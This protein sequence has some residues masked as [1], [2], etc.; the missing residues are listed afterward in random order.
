MIKGFLDG[1][2]FCADLQKLIGAHLATCEHCK[3]TVRSLLL[4]PAVKMM[5]PANL[6]D[7]LEG[8]VDGKGEVSKAGR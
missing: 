5:L 7:Y 8:S 6:K 1:I 2:E 3:A 4:I